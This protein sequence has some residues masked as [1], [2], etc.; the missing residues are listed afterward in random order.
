MTKKLAGPL[1]LACLLAYW[2]HVPALA[3]RRT[4]VRNGGV[5][6]GV[7]RWAG[8]P[9]ALAPFP[10]NRDGGVCDL[11]RS[12]KKTSP[13]L[14]IGRRGGVANTV[15]YISNISQGKP[16]QRRGLRHARK[17]LIRGC[18]Y[19]P[20]VLIA[21]V[22]SYLAMRN[23]D[24]VLHNIRM[25]GAATYNLPMPDKGTLFVKRLP[26]AGKIFLRCDAGHGWMSGIIHVT[27]HPYYVLTDPEGKFSL[28]DVP[29]GKY[30][31]KAWHEGWKV[32]RVIPKDGKPTFYE[33]QEPIELSR[34][35]TLP[36]RGKVEIEFTLSEK[37]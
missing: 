27:E 31:V 13:R 30:T 7:V 11:D 28:A 2:P 32:V 26:K 10:V 20:H 19:H 34:E 25:F 18:E 21:P 6:S 8:A 29:P 9:P 1:A 33:F 12:G 37:H 3:Y 17:W 4:P 36:E 16:L 24:P 14:V 15:V 5:I 22:G 23:D 35:V